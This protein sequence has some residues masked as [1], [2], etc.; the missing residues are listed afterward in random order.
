MVKRIMICISI[1][2]LFLFGREIYMSQSE[3]IEGYLY[4]GSEWVYEDEKAEFKL[5]LKVNSDETITAEYVYKDKVG[6]WFFVM[7]RGLG[8][9]KEGEFSTT[10]DL[11]GQTVFAGVWTG[12]VKVSANKI[13][14]KD[15]KNTEYSS[16]IKSQNFYPEIEEETIA[17]EIKRIELIRK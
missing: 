9:W 5:N 15:I 16:E 8:R 11:E 17:D 4:V 13:I 10:Y 1:F 3:V 6:K 2:L 7:G 14:I 12:S